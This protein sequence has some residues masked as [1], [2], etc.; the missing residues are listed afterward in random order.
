MKLLGRVTG[1]LQ[2]VPVYTEFRVSGTHE[3]LLLQMMELHLQW[4]SVMEYELA[5][6]PQVSI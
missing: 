5:R 2:L 1:C 3:E 6:I 4:A